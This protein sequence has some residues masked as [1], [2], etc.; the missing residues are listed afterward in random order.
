M[1]ANRRGALLGT[2]ALDHHCATGPISQA[3]HRKVMAGLPWGKCRLCPAPL[4]FY[5]RKLELFLDFLQRAI[6]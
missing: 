1:K 6:V 2:E 4:A 5:A 3:E